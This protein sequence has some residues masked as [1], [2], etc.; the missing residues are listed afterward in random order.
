[1]RETSALLRTELLLSNAWSRGLTI[2]IVLAALAL[3]LVIGRFGRR[4]TDETIPVVPEGTRMA[5]PGPWGDLEV[6]PISIACPEEL[7][8]VQG[9]EKKVTHWFFKGYTAEQLLPRLTEFGIVGELRDRFRAPG[10]WNEVEG[11]INI[12]PTSDIVLN[13]PAKSRLA[14]YSLLAS[15]PENN[16]SLIFVLA[17]TVDERFA[18][19]TV[20]PETIGA[21][22]RLCCEYGRY[23]VFSDVASIF[24]II[25]TYEERVAFLKALTRQPTMLVRLRVNSKSDVGALSAYWAKG[26]RGMDER[27]LLESLAQVPGGTYLN[28][29][30]LLPSG[31]MSRLYSFPLPANP[32]AGPVVRQDCHW[33][34]FNFFRDAGDEQVTSPEF[35]L[36]KLRDDYY[37][38]L[39]DQRYGDL[40]VFVTPDGS[41]IHSAVY[42]AANIVFTKN[43]DTQM[44]PWMFSTVQ[45][46]IDQYSF[47]VPPDRQLEVKYFRNKLL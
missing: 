13:L 37:P 21:F 2:L 38:V 28:L 11:G 30:N 1:M 26:G 31:S 17:R 14:L 19:T 3:G 33:S 10:V 41:M 25:P 32:L 36:H 23:L 6:T 16:S 20:R 47:Q 35:I 8:P 34:A 46:L 39:S 24:S 22:K 43:G 40:V 29:D 9:F 42:L 7:L 12:T 27:A 15:F 44:H 5:A 4:A 45:N 18:G